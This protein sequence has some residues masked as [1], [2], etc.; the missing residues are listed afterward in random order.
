MHAWKE[1]FIFTDCIN[2][3]LPYQNLNFSRMINEQVYDEMMTSRSKRVGYI[4][5]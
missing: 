1:I 2:I 3:N 5:I 4:Y